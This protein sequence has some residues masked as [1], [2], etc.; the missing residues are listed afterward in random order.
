MKE[1]GELMGDG[2]G[3]GIGCGVGCRGVGWGMWGD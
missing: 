1:V 2:E 3:V